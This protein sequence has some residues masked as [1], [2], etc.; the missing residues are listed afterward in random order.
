MSTD[1]FTS[2]A[3][4]TGVKWA[5]LKGALLLFDV[6]GY[7]PEIHTAFGES[8]AVRADLSV[9]DGPQSGEEYKETLVFPKGLQGQLRP[10]IG[11]KVLGRLGQGQAKSGQS[12]PWLL[13]EATETDKKTAREYLAKSASAPF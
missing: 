4:A 10:R 13:Q 3:T 7:E 9:I 12:A 6:T 1:E 2:P 11:S 5:D 8:S